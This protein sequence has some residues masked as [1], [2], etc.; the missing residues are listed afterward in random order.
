MRDLQIFHS[1]ARA[2]TSSL[3]RDTILRTIMQQMEPF[4]EAETWSLLLV[5]EQRRELFYAVAGG[6]MPTDAT[7]AT[8][9]EMRIPIGQGFAG[10]VAEHGESLIVPEVELDGRFMHLAGRTDDNSRVRSAICMPLR[11]RRETLGVI[12][13]INCRVET[14][15]DYTI[16]FLH[17]LCDYAAIAIENARAVERIQELTITDDCTGLYNLRY[18]YRQMEA[19]MERTQRFGSMFSLI[20]IDLDHFK[21]V[22]DH[23]GHLI[24]S[25]LLAEVGQALRSQV[26]GVDSVFRYGGDEFTV[27]LP[28]SDKLAARETAIRL[29]RFLREKA[30]PMSD[31]PE[32][33]IRASMGVATYPEDGA[34]AQEIIRAADQM[35]Y[36]VKGMTRDSVAIAGM[37]MLP[38]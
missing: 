9:R 4:F 12:Q 8:L 31:G 27:L 10:W 24:G 37:G 22:N 18:L 19:E 35:M 16:S 1:V 29:N 21:D 32:L 17:L 15:S 36:L 20:F 23:Y 33:Q 7:E 13:L 30:F 14:L 38:V 25:E 26:R 5:D 11:V 3:D 6:T 2:L 34:T 28:G